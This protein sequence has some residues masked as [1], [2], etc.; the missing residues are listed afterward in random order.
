VS[1]GSIK[2]SIQAIAMS[3]E[4]TRSAQADKRSENEGKISVVIAR[5]NHC[6]IVAN[7]LELVENLG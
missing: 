3:L 6:G 5:K 2:Q 7:R 1:A 4:E